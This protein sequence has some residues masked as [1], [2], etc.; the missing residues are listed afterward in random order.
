MLVEFE[1][2]KGNRV[3]VNTSDFGY[4]AELKTFLTEKVEGHVFMPLYRSGQW[5]GCVSLFKVNNRTFPVGLI[6]DVLRFHKI[7]MKDIPLHTCATLKVS[8]EIKNLYKGDICPIRNYDLLYDPNDR[9]YQIDAI[10][11][12][13]KYRNCI[14]VVGTGGGKSLCLTYIWKI[15]NDS[16]KISNV[17]LGLRNNA[18]SISIS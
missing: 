5:D 3:Q 8:D 14:A 1:L 6:H 17:I 9:P 13:I 4:L 15:L 10:E 7:F 12:I 18:E 16:K 11:K 2:Y